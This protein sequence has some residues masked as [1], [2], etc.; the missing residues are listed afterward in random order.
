MRTSLSHNRSS[1]LKNNGAVGNIIKEDE[2]SVTRKNGV[3]RELRKISGGVCAPDGFRAGST[4]CGIRSNGE[5]DLAIILAD[6]R[7]A[8][9]A[10]FSTAKNYGAPIA[11]CKKRIQ[12]GQGGYARAI[13]ANGGVANVY[14]PN[15]ERFAR[16]VCAL[17]ERHFNIRQE[18]VLIASTGELGKTLS[19]AAFEKGVEALT[20][21]LGHEEE[22][23]YTAAHALVHEDARPLHCAYTFQ[24]GDFPCKIG[25]IFKGSVHVNPNMA[26]TLVFLTTDVNITPAMLQRAL[27]AE[28]KETLNLLD[29]DG[30]P[31]PN[32][33]VCIL[34]NGKAGNYPISCV[35]SEYKKFA[36][37]LRLTLVEICKTLIKNTKGMRKFFYCKVCGAK[38]K[39]VSR[40]LSKSI[41]HVSS[42]KASIARGTVDVES[43]LYLVGELGGLS[44]YDG[45]KIELESEKGRLLVYDDGRKMPV[46]LDRANEVLAGEEIGVCVDL[47]NG[48]YQSIARSCLW[49]TDAK[50]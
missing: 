22:F 44:E 8:A 5:K 35:D 38:S 50:A 49:E 2:M 18:E 40:S 29:I 33:T 7:C 39:Q 23:S 11:I 21:R 20:K 9:A 30:A 48:Y 26:T 12:E 27:S 3:D 28:V 43:V 41:V 15:G 34:A 36:F 10:V 42:L 6:T 1:G 37:A 47:N 45:I 31:S 13:I 17:V 25:A 32:D 14:L 19:F 16:D 24:L 4:A 46:I